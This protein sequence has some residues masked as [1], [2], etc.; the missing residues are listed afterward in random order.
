MDPELAEPL[1][2]ARPLRRDAE[3]NRLA[4][5]RAAAEVIGERGLEASLDDVA[6]R[7]GVGVGTVYRRFPGKEALTEALFEDRL[8]SLVAIAEQ[9]LA[10]PDPRCGLHAYLEGAAEL[11]VADRGLRQILMYAPF[12]RDQACHARERLQPVVGQLI[13]R[14]QAAGAVRA[15]LR[16]SDIPSIMLM[17]AAA[18][19]YARPVRPQAWRRYLV[20]LLDSL[21][22]AR[23][24]PAALPEPALT[25]GE[26]QLAMQARRAFCRG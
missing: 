7:A 11:L 20:L 9:A 6:R 12:G 8:D 2:Q 17:L 1:C 18:A 3:R 22:P 21:A 19:D 10:D 13:E 26:V 14:A 15:D 24:E 4:I 25:P 5:L 16:S 23:D